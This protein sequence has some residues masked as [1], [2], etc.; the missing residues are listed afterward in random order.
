M[1][2]SSPEGRRP[3]RR[4][5]GPTNGNGHANVAAVHGAEIQAAYSDDPNLLQWVLAK[6]SDET[7][8]QFTYWGEKLGGIVADEQPMDIGD[9][10]WTSTQEAID[11]MQQIEG[12]NTCLK[13][14]EVTRISRAVSILKNHG[15]GELSAVARKVAAKWKKTASDALQIARGA[16]QDMYG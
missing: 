2:S 11:I 5:G 9:A 13:L 4:H 15:N 16:L 6:P 12:Y 1:L 3:A 10:G 14:L 7:V 8:K